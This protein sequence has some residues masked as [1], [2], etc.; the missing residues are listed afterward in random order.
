MPSIAD[1][2]TSARSE[3]AA[4]AATAN[5]SSPLPSSPDNTSD[6]KQPVAFANEQQYNLREFLSCHALPQIVSITVPV[7]LE[8]ALEV[9]QTTQ[10]TTTV[11]NNNSFKS[12][13]D[14][15]APIVFYRSY[16]PQ[17]CEALAYCRP[18]HLQLQQ[19]QHEQQDVEISP[20][21]RL[22]IPQAYA[23]W[24]S[25]VDDVSLRSTAKR[26]T[27]LEAAITDSGLKSGAE[28]VT[29]GQG[30]QKKILVHGAPMPAFR[31]AA[32]VE[33]TNKNSHKLE[34][35]VVASGK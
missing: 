15:Q 21:V 25:V 33:G 18:L 14:L 29:D 26:Y 30:H 6:K 13:I 19:H 1:S 32:V 34:P 10:Q 31:R 20:P 4:T 27:T 3:I 24:F 2:P 23:G 8:N 11:L 28:Q 7:Q 35:V 5:P 16:T 12:D 22:F 17:R 9:E